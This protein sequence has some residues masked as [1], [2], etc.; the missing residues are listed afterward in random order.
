MH[1]GIAPIGARCACLLTS[2]CHC[3][4]YGRIVVDMQRCVDVICAVL[5]YLACHCCGCVVVDWCVL[6]VHVIDMLGMRC[7][8]GVSGCVVV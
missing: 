1:V 5:C 6:D 4:Y 7:V 2:H 8:V 3:N